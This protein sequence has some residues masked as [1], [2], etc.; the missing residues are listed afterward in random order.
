MTK[1]EF[2]KLFLIEAGLDSS[3]QS[4]KL[5]V[6]MLWYTPFSPIGFRL[7]REGSDFLSNV[8]KLTPYAFTVSK[9][10]DSKKAKY[11]IWLSKYLTG[12]F[13]LSGK[14]IICYG[15][16]DAMMIGLHAGDLYRYLE[17]SNRN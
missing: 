13:Y 2:T 9:S 12:P 14:T 17:D 16:T 3:N 11:S 10:E 6:R 8:V 4:I 15:E 1:L 7:T 5:Y